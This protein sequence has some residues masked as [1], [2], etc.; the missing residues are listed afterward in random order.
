M[1]TTTPK[2]GFPAPDPTEAADGPVQILALANSV[3]TLLST[4]TLDMT[5]GTTKVKAPS[6]SD[7]AATKGYIDGRL[8]IGAAAS[9]PATATDG[10]LF[11]GY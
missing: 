7:H 11:F 3:E 8:V 5:S 6:A 10:T 2:Y 1:T 9:V 4:G